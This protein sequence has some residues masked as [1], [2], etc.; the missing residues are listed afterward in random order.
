MRN[1]PRYV[2][3]LILACAILSSTSSLFAAVPTTGLWKVPVLIIKYFPLTPDGK[4]IDIAVTSNVDAPLDKIRAKCQHMTREAMDALDEGS[5]FRA[6]KNDKA[7][8]SLHYKVIGEVEYLEPMPHNPAK[9][10]HPDY[11]RIL[12][13]ANIKQWVEE[14]GVKEVWIWGYHSKELAPWESNMASPFGDISNSDRDPKDLPI[15]SK[16]YTVYHYNYER[17]TSEAVHNH[18]HQIEAIMRHSGGVLWR[19]FEGKKGAWRAGNCHFPPN[20]ESDYD[21][22]NKRI[23]QSDIEDWKPEGFGEMKPLNCD[24][25]DGDSLK[26]FIYWMR[27]IPGKD[28]GLQYQGKKLTNWWIFMGDYDEAQ[29]NKIG[30]VEDK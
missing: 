24:K 8:A 26:W 6:Y 2:Q 27:S 7:I 28:N 21:W 5:R 17:G 11:I 30:M 22:A 10:G 29:K 3:V 16:T 13:R 15:L 9:K 14:Q 19:T 4:K 1:T 12:E 25:W 23:V 20:A 18:I